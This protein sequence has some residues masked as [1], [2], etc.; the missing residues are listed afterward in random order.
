MFRSRQR[1]AHAAVGGRTEPP[2]PGRCLPPAPH[3]GCV[4]RTRCST[5]GLHRAS[6]R[7]SSPARRPVRACVGSQTGEAIRALGLSRNGANPFFSAAASQAPAAR[8]GYIP[9]LRAH[10][11]SAFR[12]DGRGSG[13][14]RHRPPAGAAP[15]RAAPRRSDSR[16]A[17]GS[18]SARG[19]IRRERGVVPGH[20][21]S[22]P[23][24]TAQRGAPVYYTYAKRMK[25]ARA[26]FVTVS[27]SSPNQRT[28]PDFGAVFRQLRCT[29][30]P[31][32]ARTRH[33]ELGRSH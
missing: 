23:T 30:T 33:S 11:R 5:A 10:E 17:Q 7:T 14:G 6:L 9:D 28:T 31:T 21:P 13:R 4:H 25:Y 8:H 27:R 15:C 20:L 16:G 22:L 24:D 19:A 3:R 32:A 29:V 12:A 18:G 26:A 1:S 2:A